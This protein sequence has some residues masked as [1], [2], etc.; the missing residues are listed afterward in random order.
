MA[1]SWALLG[2]F[3][4]NLWALLGHL[5]HSWGLRGATWDPLGPHRGHPGPSLGPLGATPGPYKA[6]RGATLGSLGAP[7]ALSWAT[8]GPSWAVFRPSWANLG[9]CVRLVGGHLGAILCEIG[10]IFTLLSGVL[11]YYLIFAFLAYL[12]QEK[13]LAS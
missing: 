2:P 3:C 12:S 8:L 4:G 6:H 1:L 5:G 11:V 9:P 7:V 10:L 13:H